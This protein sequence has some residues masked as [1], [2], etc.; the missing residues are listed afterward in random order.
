MKNYIIVNSNTDN[1][2]VVL[3]RFYGTEDDML[4]KMLDLAKKTVD[5]DEDYEETEIP[6]NI[7]DI[8][9]N[10]YSHTW[11]IILSGYEYS[12]CY[13]AKEFDQIE[14]V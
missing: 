12:E 9:F 7:C 13:V 2:N 11:S 10:D 14:L 3:Y 1:D 4:R 6:E 5:E 8:D